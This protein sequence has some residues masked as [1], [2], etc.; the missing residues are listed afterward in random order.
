MLE[1]LDRQVSESAA[2]SGKSTWTPTVS[3]GAVTINIINK[4]SIT[5]TK[6]VTFISLI[7]WFFE[8]LKLN[9]MIIKL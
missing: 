7:G 4:T 2:D 1:V 5:S 6:G 9:A 8:R 3:K